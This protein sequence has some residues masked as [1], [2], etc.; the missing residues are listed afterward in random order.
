MHAT[1]TAERRAERDESAAVARWADV[2]FQL[3]DALMAGDL[4]A[5]VETPKYHR[6]APG[7]IGSAKR[8]AA[9]MAYE[10]MAASDDVWHRTLSVLVHAAQGKDVQVEARALLAAACDEFANVQTGSEA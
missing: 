10:H 8:S 6:P 3:L 7:V 9:D 2:R 5:M 4:A 1:A